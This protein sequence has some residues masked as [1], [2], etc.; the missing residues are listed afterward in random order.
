MRD[1]VCACV[2]VFCF[3]SCCY[4][5]CS[6]S[7]DCLTL[8]FRPSAGLLQ[9]VHMCVCCVLCMSCVGVVLVA[10]VLCVCFVCCVL[11]GWYVVCCVCCV[12]Y[13]CADGCLAVLAV[14]GKNEN[15]NLRRFGKKQAMHVNSF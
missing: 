14:R 13:V 11:S 7:L 5:V 2:C 4:G 12:G 9:K 1:C 10:C 15:H 8:A 6:D 3:G